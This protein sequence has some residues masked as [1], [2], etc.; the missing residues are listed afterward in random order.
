MHRLDSGHFADE[1]SLD[2]IVTK[3]IEFHRT[4]VAA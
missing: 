3:M 4:H 1:D 2:T